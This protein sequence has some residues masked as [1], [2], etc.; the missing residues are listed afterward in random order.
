MQ[1]SLELLSDCVVLLIGTKRLENGYVIQTDFAVDRISTRE[2][3]LNAVADIAADLG[4]K[5]VLYLNRVMPPIEVGRIEV[6]QEACIDA[7]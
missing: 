4:R 3:M 7:S 6:G 2:D 5:H 1:Y